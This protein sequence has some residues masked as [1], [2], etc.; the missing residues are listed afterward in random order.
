VTLL[1]S[2][3]RRRGER[4]AACVETSAAHDVVARYGQHLQ[5]QQ[6]LAIITIERYTPSSKAFDNIHYVPTSWSITFMTNPE[7]SATGHSPGHGT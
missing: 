4:S 3:L 6:G 2:F 5:D 7:Y 1:L